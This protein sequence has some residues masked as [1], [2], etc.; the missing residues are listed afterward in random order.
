MV[1][2]RHAKWAIPS[3][4]ADQSRST[5][6]AADRPP[7]AMSLLDPRTSCNNVRRADSSSRPRSYR[8]PGV[9]LGPKP[10]TGHSFFS[11]CESSAALGAARSMAAAVSG[12]QMI[13]FDADSCFSSGHAAWFTPYGNE[14]AP[15]SLGGLRAPQAAQKVDA[16]FTRAYRSLLV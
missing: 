7:S 16:D 11:R 10:C 14:N 6:P 1:A 3:R 5:T 4:R 15:S 8:P 13:S 12:Q 2:F 9:Q